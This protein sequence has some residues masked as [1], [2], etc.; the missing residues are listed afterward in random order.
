MEDL[1]PRLR[2]KGGPV[3][4]DATGFPLMIEAVE[5]VKVFI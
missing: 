2:Q 4:D 3:E 1:I 5:S